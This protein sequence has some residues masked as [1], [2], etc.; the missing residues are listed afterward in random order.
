[1]GVTLLDARTL[2]DLLLDEELD[3]LEVIEA[4]R[5]LDTPIASL[6]LHDPAEPLAAGPGAMILA[7]GAQPGSSACSRIVVEAGTLG[8]AAVVF[9]RGCVEQIG[10]VSDLASIS[11]VA[12]LT[13]A[14][15]LS[16]DDVYSMFRV[17]VLE[18]DVVSIRDK[19]ASTGDAYGLADAIAADTGAGVLIATAEWRVAGHSSAQEPMDDMHMHAILHRRIS[20]ERLRHRDTD[21]VM[22]RLYA[23]RDPVIFSGTSDS[24]PRMA[25]MI[26]SGS[27]LV[28]SVW[29]LEGS[30]PL[31]GSVSEAV[32]EWAPAIAVQLLRR[33]ALE[34]FDQRRRGTLIKALLEGR[35]HP[36]LLSQSGLSLSDPH[37]VLALAVRQPVD[38]PPELYQESLLHLVE[39][40]LS[41]LERGH[42]CATIGTRVYAILPTTGWRG[43]EAQLV[44][45]VREIAERAEQVGLSIIA[46]IGTPAPSLSVVH[47]SRL[48][49]DQ[50]LQILA[51]GSRERTVASF[52]EVSSIAYLYRFRDSQQPL[53]DSGLRSLLEHDSRHGTS[54]VLTLDV[55]LRCF[56]NIVR[57]AE[58]TMVHPNTFRYRLHRAIEIG[59]LD[60]D[61]EDERLA[62]SLALWRLNSAAEA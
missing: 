27:G 29:L 11:G 26:R 32:R 2:A 43:A 3:V 31:D 7:I 28:G 12:I 46:G 41:P 42:I 57:A 13:V 59:K 20:L 6:V 15:D 62:L 25:M 18:N 24:R 9:R 60:L 35:A 52:S 38:Q 10:D 45:I 51:D 21:G 48:E 53:F 22:K 56:G 58:R 17:R 36:Q 49:A 61:H 55:Y 1:M 23:S 30:R 40:H 5:G 14:S 44:T 54:Y 34:N 8:A 37:V 19:D 47:T 4:P 33:R 16:W 50:V 39:A